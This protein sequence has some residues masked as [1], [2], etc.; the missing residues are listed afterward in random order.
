MNFGDLDSASDMGASA[1]SS[2]RAIH[3][4]AVSTTSNVCVVMISTLGDAVDFGD[5]TET[6]AQTSGCSNAH[7]GL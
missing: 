7:G 1:A 6:S 5:L 3:Q 2:T 4:R